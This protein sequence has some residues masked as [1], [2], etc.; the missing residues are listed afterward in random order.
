MR[1]ISDERLI[2]E[3]K[4]ARDEG[5]TDLWGGGVPATTIADRIDCISASFVRQR[6]VTLADE[7]KLER[8]QG[9][10]PEVIEGES[11]EGLGPRQSYLPL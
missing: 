3:V 9:I 1:K 8:V 11:A 7:G 5:E 4:Q 10:P 2:S 6:L